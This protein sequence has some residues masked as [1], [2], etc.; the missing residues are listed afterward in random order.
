MSG[1]TAA[2]WTA[3]PVEYL[4]ISVEK[5]MLEKV[6]FSDIKNPKTFC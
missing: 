2:I 4:L 5:I 6:A 3:A 1:N